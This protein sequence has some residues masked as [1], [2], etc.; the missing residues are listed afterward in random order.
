MLPTN[1]RYCVT[2]KGADPESD[3]GVIY[4]ELIPRIEEGLEG[5]GKELYTTH[6]T[7][8][9]LVR[10]YL[11]YKGMPMWRRGD[12]VWRNLKLTKCAPGV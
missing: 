3:F 9:A 6:S 4:I 7:I 8:S 1:T 5:H 11:K 12:I 2:Y 10:S